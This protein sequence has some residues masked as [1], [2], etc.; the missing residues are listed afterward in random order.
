MVGRN[1]D[2][3]EHEGY[4]AGHKDGPYAVVDDVPDDWLFADGLIGIQGLVD[5]STT[6]CPFRRAGN[7][8][9]YPWLYPLMVL[10]EAQGVYYTRM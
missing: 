9:S 4:L 5:S 2:P 6:H 7:F 10:E 3:V 1:V 8:K